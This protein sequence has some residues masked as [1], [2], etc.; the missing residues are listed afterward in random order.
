[1]LCLD[2]S[3]SSDFNCLDIRWL[4]QAYHSSC[5]HCPAVSSD[6]EGL[7]MVAKRGAGHMKQ[8]ESGL[9]K[10]LIPGL[11]LGTQGF[12]PQ[13]QAVS[14][15]KLPANIVPRCSPRDGLLR[16]LCSPQGTGPTERYSTLS[17][18]FSGKATA[19]WLAVSIACA[20]GL[21]AAVLVMRSKGKC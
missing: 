11:Q 1:M 3:A 8:H 5:L 2:L 9:A 13:G 14:H 7:E 12:S 17:Q 15:N 16:S 4:T 18:Q 21:T 10:A 6:A 19:S 20:A